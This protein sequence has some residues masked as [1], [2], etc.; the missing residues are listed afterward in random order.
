MTRAQTVKH[1]GRTAVTGFR[2]MTPQNLTS[3][4]PPYC[5]TQIQNQNHFMP[6][7][8]PEPSESPSIPRTLGPSD[9]ARS[10]ASWLMTLKHQ[11]V[12]TEASE[13]AW[14]PHLDQDRQGTEAAV[15]TKAPGGARPSTR[16]RPPRHRGG[17]CHQ[18]AR[19]SKAIHKTKTSKAPRRQLPPRRPEEQGHIELGSPDTL[20]LPPRRPEKHSSPRT[21][22]HVAN[23][24]MLNP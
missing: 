10:E 7:E 11:G 21:C 2:A 19:R 4:P 16:P 22:T 18:G 24:L 20:A 17:S 14:P 13:R 9:G 5:P 15:A 8:T 1:D 6:F 23:A 12:A 3:P